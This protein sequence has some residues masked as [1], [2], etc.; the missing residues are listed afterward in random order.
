MPTAY[1]S[2]N[3]LPPSIRDVLPGVAR[4]VF[5]RAYNNTGGDD[6]NRSRYAWAAV[7]KAG[8]TR[9]ANGLWVK[10]V[11]QPRP[12]YVHRKVTNAETLV[13]WAQGAGLDVLIDASDMHVTL[14]YSKSPV[15]WM[16]I[17]SSWASEVVIPA[18]GARQLATF[19]KDDDVLVLQFRSEELEWRHTEI[20]EAGASWDWDDYHPHITL[21]YKTTMTQAR[22]DTIPPFQDEI[23][24][25]PE[26]FEPLDT[27]W[28]V[29][30][31]L[32]GFGSVRQE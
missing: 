14:A 4:Q 22:L 19:G 25:G 20:R 6:R 12:L 31:R 21:S 2:T 23:R 3:D 16:A 26:I 7:R 29:G 28:S 1:K 18:G 13:R 11:A 30:K 32:A 15:D 17:P 8:F 5:M 27:E 24:L 10:K 9:S